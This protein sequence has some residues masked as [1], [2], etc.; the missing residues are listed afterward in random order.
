MSEAITNSSVSSKYIDKNWNIT[1][2][3]LFHEN[4]Y[5]IDCLNLSI[6]AKDRYNHLFIVQAETY[7][8]KLFAGLGLFVAE[9]IGVQEKHL[10]Y[11]GTKVSTADMHRRG[12]LY[13][14]LGLNSGYFAHLSGYF[15]LDTTFH[16]S[17]AR[18]SNSSCTL[19]ATFKVITSP[20]SNHKVLFL[21]G[22]H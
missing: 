1:K 16:G 3:S 12:K 20:N 13:R 4:F 9:F 6:E 5:T 11:A 14:E 21:C 8:D 15:H 2:P 18:F 22:V 17:M 19:N 10:E 7:T